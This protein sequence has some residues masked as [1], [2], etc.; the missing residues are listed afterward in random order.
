VIG[1]V[2]ARNTLLRSMTEGPE[3]N[4][5]GAHSSPCAPVCANRRERDHGQHQLNR[6]AGEQD[7]LSKR[8]MTMVKTRVRTSSPWLL[9]ALLL[10][11]CQ[12][13]QRLPETKT[14]AAASAEIPL[15]QAN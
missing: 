2:G 10:S 15:E 1:V 12:P 13:I 4:T 9:L 3:L 5:L 8:N 11:A 14:A 7:S 6:F